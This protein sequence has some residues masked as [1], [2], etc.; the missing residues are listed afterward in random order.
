MSVQGKGP[1]G[2]VFYEKSNPFY[3][4]IINIF[5]NGSYQLLVQDPT[6]GKTHQQAHGQTTID[7][8]AS[9]KI[10]VI[11]LNHTIYVYINTQFVVS[12]RD[13]NAS[14][15]RVGMQCRDATE[16]STATFSSAQVWKL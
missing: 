8:R 7:P 9:N 1:C 15:G 11:V 16:T 4:D 3:A 13:D 10:A 14:D 12:G 5:S 2:L 6:D